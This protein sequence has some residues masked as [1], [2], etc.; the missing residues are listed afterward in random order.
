MATA[1]RVFQV[2]ISE[3]LRELGVRQQ[4]LRESILSLRRRLRALPEGTRERPFLVQEIT[5]AGAVAGE[6]ESLSALITGRD[7]E[8][9]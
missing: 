9:D 2:N 8:T 6:L 1:A 3:L 4:L 7:P 5:K